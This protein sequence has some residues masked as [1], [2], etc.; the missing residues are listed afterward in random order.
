MRIPEGKTRTSGGDR[1]HIRH[2]RRTGHSGAAPAV[3]RRTDLQRLAD[4]SPT[5]SQL[6]EYSQLAKATVTRSPAS[7][8]TTPPLQPKLLSKDRLNVVGEHHDESR[9]NETTEREIA[10]SEAGGGYWTEAEF[11]F[12][13]LG[14]LENDAGN[15]GSVQADPHIYRIAHRT[16]YMKKHASILKTFSVTVGKLLLLPTPMNLKFEHGYKPTLNA[17]LRFINGIMDEFEQIEIELNALS[18]TDA[19]EMEFM[20]EH[21]NFIELLK[22]RLPVLMENWRGARD[23][24]EALFE[25]KMNEALWRDV[26]QKVDSLLDAGVDEVVAAGEAD[27]GNEQAIMQKR[28]IVMNTAAKLRSTEQ[29]VWKIGDE[30]ARDIMG[31]GKDLP[32]N[33]MDRDDFYKEPRYAARLKADD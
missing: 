11:R 21:A 22:A 7:A 16:Q 10:Q 4:S 27:F 30:H 8:A 18:G 15:T 25:D 12:H 20:Q 33:L 2:A 23:A 28:N 26:K 9:A 17:S 1:T 3:A 24:V 13:P 29:G 5:V 19:Q 6:S 14:I 31:R 32:Y